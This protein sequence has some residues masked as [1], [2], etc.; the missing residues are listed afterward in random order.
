MRR[1]NFR[2]CSQFEEIITLWR[3]VTTRPPIWVYVASIARP[4]LSHAPALAFLPRARGASWEKSRKS[5]FNHSVLIF[6]WVPPNH[7]SQS[8]LRRIHSSNT[9][10]SLKRGER[11][12]RVY[13]VEFQNASQPLGHTKC[14]HLHGVIHAS[15]CRA[16]R[17]LLENL[18]T[19]EGLKEHW[20]SWWCG[21]PCDLWPCVAQKLSSNSFTLTQD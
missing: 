5:L 4:K 17:S 6:F 11:L 13:T 15:L 10:F 8:I 19:D 1:F 14:R 3:W 7:S 12:A 2:V 16:C 20:A 18:S 21:K 9:I